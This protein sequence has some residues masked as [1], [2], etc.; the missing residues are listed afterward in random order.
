MTRTEFAEVIGF[1]ELSTGKPI[2]ENEDAALARTKLYYQMLGDLPLD[3]LRSACE[4]LVCERKWPSFPQIAEIREFAAMVQEPGLTPGEAWRLARQLAAKYDPD[5]ESEWGFVVNGRRYESHWEAVID[6]APPE[7]VMAIKQF[8]IGALCYA[9]ENRGV[10]RGQFMRIFE[11]L[12][13]NRRQQAALPAPLRKN[14][15]T[16]PVRKALEHVWTEP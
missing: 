14:A 16:A 12:T 2:H 11:Q 13:Q 15:M 10:Q 1:L 5:R 6:G 7:V 3:V 4:R 9:G 8:G